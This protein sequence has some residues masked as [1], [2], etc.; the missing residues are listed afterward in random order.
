MDRALSSATGTN[1]FV[2]AKERNRES[3]HTHMG[4]EDKGM[5]IYTWFNKHLM[6]NAPSEVVDKRVGGKQKS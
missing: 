3:R 4:E 6:H 5:D 2:K 1:V